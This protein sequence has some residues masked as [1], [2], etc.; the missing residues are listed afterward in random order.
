LEYVSID[1][2]GKKWYH[3]AR[4]REESMETAKKVHDPKNGAI[5]SLELFRV[6]AISDRRLLSN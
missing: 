1:A 4:F 6:T 3:V 2:I 5:A